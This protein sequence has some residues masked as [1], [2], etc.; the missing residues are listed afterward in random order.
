MRKFN[1]SFLPAD[2][3]AGEYNEN[4]T[5]IGLIHFKK[6]DGILVSAPS[7]SRIINSGTEICVTITKK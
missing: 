2:I 4:D 6:A 7:I 3:T 5:L 1:Q